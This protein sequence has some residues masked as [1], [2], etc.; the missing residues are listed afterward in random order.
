MQ[1]GEVLV[2]RIEL[3]HARKFGAMHCH[4]TD[5]TDVVLWTERGDPATSTAVN[6]AMNGGWPV[7]ALSDEQI[8]AAMAGV[9]VVT[10]DVTVRLITPEELMHRHAQAR[11]K[12]REQGLRGNQLPPQL[13]LQRAEE[14]CQM[15]P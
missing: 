12:M 11:A 4:A 14:I 6:D 2:T 8:D 7:V 13:T 5:G 10:D 3:V 1:H 15:Q 9:P